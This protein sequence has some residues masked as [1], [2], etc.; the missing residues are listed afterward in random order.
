MW[1]DGVIRIRKL[2]SVSL[3]SRLTEQEKTAISL[4]QL[5]LP[6]GYS[7]AADSRIQTAHRLH[8]P[9][10]AGDPFCVRAVALWLPTPR[11]GTLSEMNLKRVCVLLMIVDAGDQQLRQEFMAI[12]QGR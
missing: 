11:S 12:K 2:Q 4:D 1:M 3:L 6:N 7:V 9:E 5:E 8:L 10:T